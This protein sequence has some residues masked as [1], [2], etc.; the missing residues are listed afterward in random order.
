[1]MGW[2][3]RAFQ[4]PKSA[5]MLTLLKSRVIPL[6]QYCWHSGVL[7]TMEDKRCCREYRL[8]YVFFVTH[9]PPCLYALVGEI[10][11]ID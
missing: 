1:M 2:V 8:Q 9:V 4:S 10:K 11:L 5:L 6:L 3:L 7:L